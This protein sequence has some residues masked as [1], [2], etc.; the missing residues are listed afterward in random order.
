VLGIVGRR[1]K[2]RR[3]FARPSTLPDSNNEGIA[4]APEAECVGGF[5]KFFWSDD[6][7]FAGHALRVDSIPCGAL[8]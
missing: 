1:F 3:A 4:L 7:H 5:E 2:V 6:S 8:F